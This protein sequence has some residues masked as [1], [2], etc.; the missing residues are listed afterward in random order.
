[1]RRIVL[2]LIMFATDAGYATAQDGPKAAVA[3]GHDQ[4][5]TGSDY[6]TEAIGT[7]AKGRVD[8]QIDINPQGL[9]ENCIIMRSSGFDILDQATCRLILQRARFRPAI[10]EAGRPTQGAYR[11]RVHWAEW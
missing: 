4:W 3:I 11:D 9:P 8:F 1:M 5:I 7:G 6:P 2:A 10:D